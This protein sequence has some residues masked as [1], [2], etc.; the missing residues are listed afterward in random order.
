MSTC[1]IRARSTIVSMAI[2]AVGLLLFVWLIAKV[3]SAADLDG[4]GQVGWGLA[5][6]PGD[7]GCAVRRAGTGVDAAV[8]SR[9]TA[10][11]S[12]TRSWPWSA[13]TRSATSRRSARSSASRPRP[14]SCAT[15]CRSAPALTA[16]AIE[17]VFYTLSVAAMIAAGIIALLLRGGLE[18]ELRLAARL[19]S[20]WCWR[21]R[22]RDMGADAA[23][24][25]AQ[26]GACRGRADR[27]RRLAVLTESR[28]S[29][30]SKRKST[31]SRRGAAAPLAQSSPRS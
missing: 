19:A 10:C 9:R 15:A 25:C 31:R 29:A 14:P 23:A 28:R 5:G 8:S 17:N 21:S 11:G 4:L 30:A 1:G 18:R 7:R 24:G 20:S 16:L 2:V 27:C 22:R 12:A 13:A 3:G 26:P 6:R